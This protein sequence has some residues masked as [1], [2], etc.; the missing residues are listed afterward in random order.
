MQRRFW[1]HGPSREE[2]L[3]IKSCSSLSFILCW[4]PLA[5]TFYH[6][7][8]SS[9]FFCY[10]LGNG[11]DIPY[12]SLLEQLLL[13]YKWFISTVIYLRKIL[14][15]TVLVF[16]PT[17]PLFFF[18]SKRERE[19]FTDFICDDVLSSISVGKCKRSV[20]QTPLTKW[21]SHFKSMVHLFRALGF[22]YK[23]QCANARMYERRGLRKDWRIPNIMTKYKSLQV[24]WSRQ[25]QV[26]DV[27][28]M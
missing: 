14:P 4:C 1:E 18:Q 21:P 19:R 20:A 8:S 3:L 7:C 17:L 27:K 22:C 13:V 23:L 24:K 25:L 5:L 15:L 26:S 9:Q 16:P 12:E 2:S 28:E 11:I 10:C 6:Y